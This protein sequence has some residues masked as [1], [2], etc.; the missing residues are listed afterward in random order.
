MNVQAKMIVAP[1]GGYALTLDAET[2]DNWYHAA[3]IVLPDGTRIITKKLNGHEYQYRGIGTTYADR[4]F[5]ALHG[6]WL[7]YGE[8][9]KSLADVRRG[10]YYARIVLDRAMNVVAIREGDYTGL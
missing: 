6:L 3:R 2:R 10:S 5:D 7:A 9:W 1:S 4:L 8:E